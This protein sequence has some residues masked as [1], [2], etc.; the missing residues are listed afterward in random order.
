MFIAGSWFVLAS[1]RNPALRNPA[2]APVATVRQL[3]PRI[4]SPAS[5]AAGV[6]ALEDR[7]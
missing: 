2:V 6:D 5:T 4:V 1:A 3:M 7:T